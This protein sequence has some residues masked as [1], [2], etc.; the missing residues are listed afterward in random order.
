MKEEIKVRIQSLRLHMMNKSLCDACIIPTTDPHGSEYIPEHWKIREWF[1]GFTGSA[2]TLVV[3]I[4]EA[5][6]WTDSRYFLQAEEQL[7]G[8]GIKLMKQ[9][10]PDTPTIE[11]WL[12]KVLPPHSI[13]GF[14]GWT[15]SMADEREMEKRLNDVHI[16][17]LRKNFDPFDEVWKGRPSLPLSP[18][19]IHPEKY[20]GLS[21]TEKMKDVYE[22]VSKDGAEGIFISALD[23]IAWLL[24]LRGKDI[25]CNPVFTSY[26]F[27]NK[28]GGTLFIDPAKLTPEVK[29]Y[30]KELDIDI[31]P[32]NDVSYLLSRVPAEYGIEIDPKK[33][34]YAAYSTIPKEAHIIEKESPIAMMKA[35]KNHTEIEGFRHAMLR[36]GVAMVK[37]LKWLEEVVAQGEQTEMSIDE[38]LYQFRAEQDLFRGISFDTIAGYAEHGAIVHYEATPETDKP[39]RPVGLLLLDSGAQYT[40]GTT[41]LTRTIALGPVTPEEMRDYTLVLKGHIQLSSACF[42]QGTCGTQL[43]VLARQAMWKQGVNYLHGT[44]HGVGSYLCVH[45]GPHQIRMNYMPAL[46]KPGMTVTDE[47]G[48]YRSGKYG[49]R[50]ENVLLIVPYM[51][52]EFGAFYTFEPLTLC[53]IDTTPIDFSLLTQEEMQWL[54]NYHAMVY[55]RLSPLLD[56]E[57]RAWL[58]EKT[59]P[60]LN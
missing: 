29:D 33:T 31:R 56:E 14:N 4:E 41:D 30:L 57:H 16:Y 40:D 5:A 2:G 58:K 52:N 55:N 20:A 21:A 15:V 51:E 8:T 6:L 44:G 53:P 3:T 9:G 32:Y 48:I 38:K 13:L 39:L 1:S 50:T 23:E 28:M 35:V 17:C 36:D 22:Q 42:P 11:Q 27:L 43:D 18:I 19:E 49:I 60:I 10:L 45:E 24:N 12:G 7:K 37:F 26:F 59:H 47:P 34:S 25:H 46:L 54:D